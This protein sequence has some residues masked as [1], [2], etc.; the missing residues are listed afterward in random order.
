MMRFQLPPRPE[1]LN[2]IPIPYVNSLSVKLIDGKA[3]EI[4][5]KLIFYR[6]ALDTTSAKD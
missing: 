6:P 1:S 5:L 2:H 4:G 3:A